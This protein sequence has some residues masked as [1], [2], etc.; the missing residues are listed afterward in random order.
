MLI[1]KP[2]VCP[3]CRRIPIVSYRVVCAYCF[4]LVPYELRAD[5]AFTYRQRMR[6]PTPYFEALARLYVWRNETNMGSGNR[7]E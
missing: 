1:A 4:R 5:L 3:C 2:R 6:Y 7:Y